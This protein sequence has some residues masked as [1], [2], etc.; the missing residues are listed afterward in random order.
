MKSIWEID[1]DIKALVMQ[2]PFIQ[3]NIVLL[4][5]IPG[6]GP[7]SSIALL[8]E[9]GNFTLFQK[10]KQLVAYFGLDPSQRQSGTFTGSKNKLSKRGS[11][12]VRALL[13]L[14]VITAIAPQ[15]KRPAVNPVLRAYY[16]E[17]CKSK[18]HKVVMCALMHKVCN[19]IF[20]VL[21]DQ[22]PFELRQPEQHAQRLGLAA[23]A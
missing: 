15:K 20:A 1:Q 22:K 5:S 6:I 23:V 21:R 7:H 11:A 17:K 10:P 12:Y 4:Q 13:H 18:P 2:E 9:I 3:K 16:E 19:I 14:A 8:A